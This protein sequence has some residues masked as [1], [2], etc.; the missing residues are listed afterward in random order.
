MNN[1]TEIKLRKLIR[2]QVKQILNES[3]TDVNLEMIGPDV[4]ELLDA[5]NRLNGA[6][7]SGPV[8]KFRDNVKLNP[9]DKTGHTIGKNKFSIEVIPVAK[10]QP[11]PNENIYMREANLFLQKNGFQCQLYKTT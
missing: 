11:V 6:Q 1:S 3:V 5:I 2:E 8:F 4:N 7:I 9:I 10:N